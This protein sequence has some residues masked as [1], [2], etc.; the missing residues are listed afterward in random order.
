M[1]VSFDDG[2]NWQSFQQNLPVTPI[3]DLKI[4]RG[5]L[6]VS[7]M[8][9]SFWVLDNITALRD[10]SINNLKDEPILFQ[11]DTTIRYRYPKIRGNTGAATYPR[12]SVIID[13]YLPKENTSPIQL[14]ILDANKNV[15]A[16][17]VS[18]KDLIPKIEEVEDMNLS[19]VFRFVDTKLTTKAGINR[20]EWNLRQKGAWHSK[21]N[22]RFKYGP[23]VAPGIYTRKLEAKLEKDKSEK[24]HHVLSKIKNAEGAYPQQMFAAQVSYLL[25]MIS[26]ADQKIGGEA[27]KRFAVLQKQYQTLQEELK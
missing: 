10:V 12:T 15:V 18:D 21:E 5:D 16:S 6:I 25:N 19:Q 11:P 7:T 3:T 9:R 20:F 27:K 17:I 13:Y 1:F 24:A 26:G 8:G 2:K 22:R 4:F 14:E 23:M